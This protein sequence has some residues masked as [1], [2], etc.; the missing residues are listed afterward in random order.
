[1]CYIP[2]DRA[3]VFALG[4]LACADFGTALLFPKINRG[5]EM[6]VF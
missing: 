4:Y 1:M 2:G 6:K 3:S 5:N